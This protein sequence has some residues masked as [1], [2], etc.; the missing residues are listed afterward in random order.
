MDWKKERDFYLF[1]NY[2]LIKKRKEMTE[3]EN[4]AVIFF[5]F[6][7]NTREN[8]IKKL[9]FFLFFLRGG[10]GGVRGRKF[11][12][13]KYSISQTQRVGKHHIRPAKARIESS[14]SDSVTILLG[15]D[16]LI[17]NTVAV[18]Y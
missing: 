11:H 5:S 2:F 13:K 8:I 4:K 16:D 12:Q 7:P 3:S 9:F 15:N 1:T 6:L 14:S 17:I 10:G 18:T